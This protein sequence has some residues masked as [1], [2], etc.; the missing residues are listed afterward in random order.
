MG[1]YVCFPGGLMASLLNKPLLLVNADAAHA[2]VQQA[3]LPAGRPRGL[4]L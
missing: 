1:G 3:L 2:A 4:W